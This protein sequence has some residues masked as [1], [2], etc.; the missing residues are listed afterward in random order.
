M[1]TATTECAR[2]ERG[3]ERKRGGI[4]LE[5][6]ILM[7]S[8]KHVHCSRQSRIQIYTQLCHFCLPAC[9]PVCISRSALSVAIAW[10][11]CFLLSHSIC[12]FTKEEKMGSYTRNKA[13]KGFYK[14]FICN[15]VWLQSHFNRVKVNESKKS[16]RRWRWWWKKETTKLNDSATDDNWWRSPHHILDDAARERDFKSNLH[17]YIFIV[18]ARSFGPC[19]SIVALYLA[20]DV[21]VN[22]S[23]F[24]L[25]IF[26]MN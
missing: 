2:N 9:L 22:L 12:Y 8:M 15:D 1:A 24:A 18:P 4:T 3:R 17:M 23:A 21:R 13:T 14:P 11:C 10:C 16:K 6:L 20:F 25:N 26:S 5:R 7:L 19:C